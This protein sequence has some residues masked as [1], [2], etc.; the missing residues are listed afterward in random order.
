MIYIFNYI[1]YN[2]FPKEKL[3]RHTP[4]HLH[5]L[6]TQLTLVVSTHPPPVTPFLLLSQSQKHKLFPSAMH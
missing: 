6:L 2:S 4:P 5:S 1:F 3:S